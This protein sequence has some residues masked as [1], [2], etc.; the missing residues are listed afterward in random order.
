MPLNTTERTSFQGAPQPAR[1]RGRALTIIAAVCVVA[2]VGAIAYVAWQRANATP[3]VYG[4]SITANDLLT[5][6]TLDPARGVWAVG[7]RYDAPLPQAGKP[8]SALILH[9]EGGHWVVSKQLDATFGDTI[10][11]IVMPSADEGW[12]VGGAGATSGLILHYQHGSWSELSFHPHGVLNAITMVSPT[13]GWAVGGVPGA[14]GA[15]T[16]LHYIHGV[17]SE[18]PSP[19][20][21]NLTAIGMSSTTA[22][23]AA[24]VATSGQR[25]TFLRYV[26]DAWTPESFVVN[27]YIRG[28][29]APS[30]EEAWAVGDSIYHYSFGAWA[31]V[32][33]PTGA[34]ISGIAMSDPRDGWAVGD[35]SNT[36]TSVIWRY[37]NGAWTQV[38]SPTRQPLLSVA[39]ISPREAWAVGESGVIL[40]YSGGAWSLVN[41]PA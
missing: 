4:G 7:M 37:S 10:T 6:V 40:H 13:E 39:S 12:A 36:K 38:N 19:G 14:D 17:W 28:I 11:S 35:P 25:M 31:N 34:T 29:A 2:L 15:T 9:L 32:G 21:G 41:G 5:Q 22:G 20:P 3:Q 30:P 16:I 8:V 24:S 23:W 33:G 27:G 18:V 1:R 26:N